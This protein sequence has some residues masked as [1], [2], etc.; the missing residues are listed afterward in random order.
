MTAARG[1]VRLTRAKVG[2]LGLFL[3]LLVSFTYLPA[4]QNGFIFIDDPDYVFANPHVQSGLTLAGLRWALT[5]NVG[6]SWYPV[7]WISHMLDCQWYGLHPWGHHL[8]NVLLHAANTLLLF[9]LFERMTGATGRS[10]FL[11]ALFG[12]H[13]M[14]VESVAWVAERKDVLST[15]F[16]LLTLLAYARFARRQRAGNE[17]QPPAQT[18]PAPTGQYPSG[19][20]RLPASPLYWAALF[21]Y[22]LGL[23]SKPMLVTLPFVLLL[24]DYWPLQ[25]LPTVNPRS[26]VFRRRL[27]EKVPFFLLA[28]A[29]SVIT[30][31]CQTAF[32]AMRTLTSFPLPVRVE[33]ALVAYLRYLGKLFWPAELPFFYPYPAHWPWGTVLAAALIL[34]LVSAAVW[35]TRR[36]YPYLLV[37]W[38]WFAGTLVPVIGLVQVGYQSMANRYSY[39]PYIG[40]FLSLVWLA[41]AITRRWLY[42]QPILVAAGGALI[43][44]CIPATRAQIGYWKN[45]EILFQYASTVI[46][47]NWLAHARLGQAFS[48]DGRIDEAIKE[49]EEALKINPDDADTH[50]NLA[51]V[52]CRK[53]FFDEAIRHYQEVLRLNPNDVGCH[54]NLGIALFRAGRRQEAVAQFE[55]ALRVEPDNE[56]ARRNL[57]VAQGAK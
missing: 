12:L 41:E 16:G 5:S 51:N 35:M 13:P 27:L 6:G 19:I 31:R 46:E 25:R 21:F 15:F 33:N 17:D 28:F 44:A 22:V 20:S 14:H 24:L 36:N 53:G 52:L 34:L 48:K 49:Y 2:L 54:N 30:F 10:F 23:M 3:A 4:L 11:A 38:C 26:A 8:T 32:G 7:T 40:I 42:R 45:S 39:V 55:A 37:G 56:E 9:L 50:F 47:N 57:A 18:L 29:A 43:L 1:P